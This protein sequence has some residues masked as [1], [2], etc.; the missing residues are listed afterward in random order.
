ML[1]ASFVFFLFEALH[2]KLCTA[3]CDEKNPFQ[4]ATDVK[5]N[6]FTIK[7]PSYV[8]CCTA[9]LCWKGARL[10]VRRL[11]GCYF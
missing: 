2:G 3:G 4:T 5:M 10:P 9:A 7:Q 11:Y 1:F 8:I 6:H